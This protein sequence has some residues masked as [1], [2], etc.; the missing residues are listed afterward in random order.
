MRRMTRPR[1][2]HTPAIAPAS[3]IPPRLHA[4]LLWAGAA[5]CTAGLA[6]HRMWEHWAPGRLLELIVLALAS[7][8]LAW[9]LRRFA[10]LSWASAIGAVWVAALVVF[11]GPLP[12]LAVLLV[13]ATAAV[14]GSWVA[15]TRAPSALACACGLALLA[16]VLGWLLPLPVHSRWT[17]L[18]LCVVMIAMGRRDLAIRLNTIR[19]AWTGAVAV[20]PRAAALGLLALGLASIGCWLP[21]MQFDDLAYHLGLPW[22]LMTI[23]RYALDPTH[24]VWALAP[25]ASDVQHAMPQLLA[26]AEARGPLNA[27]W[28]T[29]TAAGLWRLGA[30]LKLDASAR[31]GVIALYASL[32]LTAGLAAGMQTETATAG[33]L[34]WLAWLVAR[35]VDDADRAPDAVRTGAVLLG[36]L[37]GLKLLG[38]LYGGVLLLYAALVR[39]PWPAPPVLLGAAALVCAVAGSSYVYAAAVA[40]NPFLPLFN[41]SFQSPFFAPSNFE[42]ARWQAGLSPLLPWELTFSTRAYGETLP[43]SAGFVL[44]AFAGAWLLALANRATRGLALAATTLL[45][46]VFVPLQ[47]L[48][49]AFPALVLLLPALLAASVHAAP[50]RWVWLVAGVA[51]LG[52]AFQANGNWMHRTGALKQAVLA[53]GR[54][55]P[56]LLEYAPE[57]LLAAR[58]REVNATPVLFFDARSPA[59]AELG[60]A[61]RTTAWYAPALWRASANADADASGAGWVELIRKAGTHDII[62]RRST[63]TSAQAAALQRIGATRHEVRGDAEWWQVPAGA[64]P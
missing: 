16:G 31:W 23:G 26:G 27:L 19:S 58:L 17:Y 53:A 21:T 24:Q 2:S 55:A 25:W 57:R 9:P 43:G 60:A 22:Q 15:G 35:G 52:F 1:D 7:L 36:G 10:R 45:V 49:Y 37:I 38:V 29:I 47:Y 64:Q 28:I 8:A 63:L 46:L 20:H 62:L 6:L 61:G 12:V 42:D 30:E 44:V 14:I 13:A 48:R 56:L 33:L 54:D 5:L 40:G 39:R 3:L 51:V 34:V 59:Y 32:P 50:R 18:A 4:P 41:A 11:A